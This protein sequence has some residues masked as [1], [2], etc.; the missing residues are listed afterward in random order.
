MMLFMYFILNH[1]CWAFVCLLSDLFSTILYPGL[2][3]PGNCFPQ[4]PVQTQPKRASEGTLEKER[5]GE[6]RLCLP[7]SVL[8][9]VCGSITSVLQPLLYNPFLHGSSLSLEVLQWFWILPDGLST[10]GHSAFSLVA[11]ASGV[12]GGS[13]LFSSLLTLLSPVLNSL[14]SF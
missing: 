5:K 14:C 4:A 13:L 8:Q 10:R 7:F 9:M 11:L 1:I 3:I 12:E 6:G 2:N